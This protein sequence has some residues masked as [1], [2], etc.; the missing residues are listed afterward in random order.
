MIAAKQLLHEIVRSL[1][2]VIA[3]SV[4]EPYPKAQAYMAAVILEFVARQVEERS[5]V[6]SEKDAA[7]RTLFADLMRMPNLSA[8][9]IEIG[10]V[11]EAELCELIER[12]YAERE[13]LGA[14]AFAAANNRVRQTLRHM[15]DQDLKVAGKAG[16]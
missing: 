4:A 11:G 14:E 15:L 9:A 10:K 13:R 6:E 2:E 16:D 12:L 3:P 8:G 5:D 1:R 7:M